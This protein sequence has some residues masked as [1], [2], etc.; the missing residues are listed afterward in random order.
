MGFPARRLPAAWCA[1]VSFV[2]VAHADEPLHQEIDRTIAAGL[3]DYD[4]VAAPLSTDAEFLRRVFLDLTGSI[5]SV[6]D[7]RAFLADAAADK[8]AKLID[9]LLASP[10]HA[11]RMQEFFD[12][13]LMDRRRD[14]K[15]PAAA[16]QAFLRTSFAANKPYDELV[17]D[18]LSSDGADP[19]TRP[20]AKFFLDRD[21][22]PT[23]VT[24]D[25]ARLFLGQNLQC[26]QCHDHPLV[27][28]YK[29]S[30]FY[31]IQ[32]FFNRAYLHPNA[33]DA[34]AVIAEKADGEVNFISVFDP[35]KVQKT[36][37][38]AVPGRK[39]IGDPK[40]DKGKE[41]KVAPAKDVKPIP[42]YSRLAKLASAITAE[43]NVAFRRTAANRL[44]FLMMGRGLV[45]PLD[46]DHSNNPASHPALLTLLA[47]EFAKNKYDV[48]WLLREIALSKTYQ[49][50]S[51]RRGPAVP[52]DR[53]AAAILKPL[54]PEQL[55]SAMAQASGLTDVYRKEL[56]KNLTEPALHAK[57]AGNVAPY[58]RLYGNRP[59]ETDD[60]FVS[61]LDQTLFVKHGSHVRNLIA[62]RTGSLV[63]R[64]AKLKEPS[65][66]A[67]E[68]F[69]TVYTRLPSDEERDEVAA[70]IRSTPDRTAALTDIVWAMLA[71]AEFRF[72]H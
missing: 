13:M 14:A 70:V 19:K 66:V 21:L 59:G 50:S 35:K 42:A 40:L 38:P 2:L 28:D 51:E 27:G 10:E 5:P 3:L 15:V 60:G 46:F 25:I 48:R 63:E 11:R 29:Q 26:A 41:Y 4:R 67:E 7:A 43:E 18:I 71:S 9:K 39:P 17:R 16:W 62:P 30:H 65:L 20:A 69:L 57:L 45:H 53:Y 31:G 22:E 33:Q 1:L 54:A 72:N 44:W 61:T 64:A 34:K 12:V 52:E 68:L 55:G 47:D 49:R 56:A 24:R 37:S 36:T 32:A 58:L 23:I 8:R 6:A